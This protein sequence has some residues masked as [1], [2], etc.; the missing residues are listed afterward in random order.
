MI[1]YTTEAY[2][3][4]CKEKHGDTYDYSESVYTG[5][6]NKLTII[7]KLHGRFSMTANAHLNGQGCYHCGLIKRAKSHRAINEK[8]EKITN[9]K[10]CSNCNIEKEINEFNPHKKLLHGVN[11]VCKKC[12]NARAVRNRLLSRPLPMFV[13]H[14]ICNECKECLPINNFG[15]KTAKRLSHRCMKCTVAWARSPENI[16]NTRKNKERNKLKHG[17]KYKRL[18]V[19]RDKKPA[20]SKLFISK[21]IIEDKPEN[22]DGLLFVACKKCGKMFNPTILQVY[23]RVQGITYPDGR[24]G[25]FY[26][27]DYCKDTCDIFNRKTKR[28][29]ETDSIKA[30]ARTC[31]A[32]IKKEL[33][34]SQCDEKGYKFCEKCGDTI[35]VELHHTHQVKHKGDI[36][37]SAGMILLCY[38]CHREMHTECK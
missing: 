25:N 14:K 5:T 4:K 19:E 13:T 28:K 12:N 7:C 36:N 6:N 31:Q 26:C 8:I 10:I 34:K 20:P 17:E 35:D 23:S 1:K 38:S 15:S 33:L 18:R 24:E 11:S 2:V 32:I 16:E 21:M 22:R 3:V 9:T 37:N 29:Y 30:K 27:S